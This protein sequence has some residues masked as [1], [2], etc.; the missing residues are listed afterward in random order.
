VIDYR[1]LMTILSVPRPNGSPAEGITR[2]ALT[3]WLERKGIPYQ[4]QPFKKFP[5]F[6]DCLGVW[7]ILSRGLLALAIWLRWG[8]MSVP[9]ALLGSIGGTLNYVFNW[10]LATW[11][12]ARREGNILVRFGPLNPDREVI[13]CAHYDT[14]TELL[15]HRQRTFFLKALPWGIALTL[16][17]GALGPLERWLALRVS[18]WAD[19]VYWSAVVLTV[20]LLFLAWGLGLN[21]SLG[22]LLKPS[23]RAVDDGAACAVLLGL[24]ARLAQGEIVL[25]GTR[26][27]LALFA[28]EEVNMQGSRAYLS[29]SEWSLPSAAVNL[30]VM[31]QDGDYV[32]WEQDGSA[33]RLLP[34][35]QRLNRALCKAV[36]TVTGSAAQPAGPVLSDGGSFLSAGIPATTLGTYDSRP[37]DTGF[38]RP[39]DNPDRVVMARLPEGVEILA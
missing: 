10:P 14:K 1:E 29:G 7:L 26:V 15:D 6:F 36:R 5:F 32:Y 8:C 2:R 17:L 27:T 3:A 23:Q 37:K 24:A 13:L 18:P 16:L 11:I 25:Q 21:L 22:R 30:E 31:A 34:T 28:G 19:L 38:H 12:S 20:S 4:L 39:T 35:S 33:L 9:I